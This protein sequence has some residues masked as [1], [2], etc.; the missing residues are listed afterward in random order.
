MKRGLWVLLLGLPILAWVLWTL[1]GSNGPQVSPDMGLSGNPPAGEEKES[2]SGGPPPL[3]IDTDEPLLLEDPPEDEAAGSQPAGQ[4]TADNEACFVCHAN[5]MSEPLVVRHARENVGCMD[6]HGKSY[7]HRNDE[8]NITPPDIMYPDRSIDPACKEC[9][10]KHDAP[11]VAV[12]ARWQRRCPT[13]SNPKTIVC[14]DCHGEHRLKLRTVRWDKK[15]GRLIST[16]R[17]G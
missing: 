8:N 1:G 11:A 13:K 3:E 5:Y 2:D 4:P 12:I 15:T 10:K 16:N 9:H 7:A 14:T 6:C 17:G